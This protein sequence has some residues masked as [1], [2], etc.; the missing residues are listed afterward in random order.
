[1]ITEGLAKIILYVKDMN[2][3]VSFYRDILDLPVQYPAGLDDYSQ[4]IWVE[5]ATGG[6]SLTLHFDPQ[7]QLSQDRPKLVFGVK[8][9][10]TAHQKLTE[11]GL[12]LS[13]INS[14][15]N[16]VRVADGCD[17]EGNPFSIY[18]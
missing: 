6:C 9:I 8:D 18:Q 13:H 11:R 15:L 7:K 16:N 10:E 12:Q 3:Q 14:R 5:F 1:M 2:K 4:Q 17:W